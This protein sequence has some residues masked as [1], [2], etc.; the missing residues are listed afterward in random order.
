[1]RRKGHLEPLWKASVKISVKTLKLSKIRSHPISA[2]SMLKFCLS[3]VISYK[4]ECS[5]GAPESLLF[6]LPYPGCVQSIHKRPVFLINHKRFL[7]CLQLV[8]GWL[9]MASQSSY[10]KHWP[11]LTL[12]FCSGM[13][14]GASPPKKVQT[15]HARPRAEKTLADLSSAAPATCYFYLMRSQAKSDPESAARFLNSELCCSV[16]LFPPL[17]TSC[18]IK[19]AQDHSISNRRTE[20]YLF[21]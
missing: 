14:F 9:T 5:S 15:G 10:I 1:M 13:Q 7:F 4:H 8:L 18:F 19:S 21:S 20:N 11:F 3:P 16:S 12:A 2:D 6:I 17:L